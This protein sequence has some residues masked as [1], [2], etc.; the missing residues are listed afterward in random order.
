MHTETVKLNNWRAD[1]VVYLNSFVRQETR[2][3]TKQTRKMKRKNKFDGEH[4]RNVG[5]LR[6]IMM[7]SGLLCNH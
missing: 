1:H 2:G 5:L 6:S 7:Y 4:K 3:A